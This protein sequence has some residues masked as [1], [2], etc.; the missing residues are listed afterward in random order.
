MG[1]I[2][3]YQKV[4]RYCQSV[5]SKLSNP[6]TQLREEIAKQVEMWQL[7]YRNRPLS[8]LLETVIYDTERCLEI[9]GRQLDDA[10]SVSWYLGIFTTIAIQSGLVG[11]FDN[12]FKLAFSKYVQTQNT[13]NTH[14]EPKLITMNNLDVLIYC[15]SA[16]MNLPNLSE[17]YKQGIREEAELWK[18]HLNNYSFEQVSKTVLD[19]AIKECKGMGWELS[20]VDGMTWFLGIYSKVAADSTCQEILLFHEP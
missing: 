14:Q 1:L 16:K 19:C 12:F 5:K 7:Y 10:E 3:N 9:K 2:F 13:K 6:S 17:Q 4:E 11:D 8:E 20:D 18:Q 15:Q